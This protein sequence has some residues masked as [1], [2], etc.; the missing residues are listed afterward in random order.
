[1]AEMTDYFDHFIR[2]RADEGGGSDVTTALAEGRLFDLQTINQGFV[3]A[4]SGDDRQL[5]Y[6]QGELYIEYLLGRFGPEAPG[7]LLAAFAQSAFTP[8]AIAVG[9]GVTAKDFEQG[10]QEFVE[11]HRKAMG[12]AGD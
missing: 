6:C 11:R 10:Y 8:A 7:K 5:A 3:H 4:R 2:R 1:M 12:S 9:L